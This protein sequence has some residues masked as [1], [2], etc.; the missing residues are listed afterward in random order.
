[1]TNLSKFILTPLVLLMAVYS[2]YSQITVTKIEN[3]NINT[4]VD[5]FVYSMPKTI[6]KIDIVYEKVQEIVGPLSEYTTEYLGVTDYI[7]SSKVDYNL[8]N[9]DV[10]TYNVADPNQLYF[11]QYPIERTKDEKATSFTLSDIGGLLAYNT[12]YT[13]TQQNTEVINDQTFIFK[14]GEAEF[15]YMSQYNRKEKIDTIVR[16]INIDTVT[17]NRFL[18]K[19]SWI[20]KNI[21]DKAKDAALQIEKIRE[22]RYHLMTGYQEVN[23]GSSIVYMDNQIQKLENQYLELFL[24]KKLRT[25]ERK[26]VYF[27]P[28]MV[29]KGDE[30]L[31]FANGKAVVIKV[32]PDKISGTIPD[33]TSTVSNSI[34]YRIPASANVE[35]SLG[36]N[37]FFNGRFNVNQLGAVSTIPLTNTKLQFNR[38]TGNIISIE[39]E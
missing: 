8:I 9:I 18:F 10:S 16:T 11:V 38:E 24:G 6:F 19:S 36:N 27:D 28:S 31:K 33:A 17:I 7:S 4:S 32:T 12:D 26:T 35:V 29:K 22:S 23:Y 3:K 1:M 37:P 2:G 30:L 21:N 39:R 34:Y 20:D 13:T 5:G 14:S 25:I 15:P